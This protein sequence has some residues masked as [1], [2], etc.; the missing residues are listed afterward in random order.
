LEKFVNVIKKNGSLLQNLFRQYS[1][2]MNNTRKRTFHSAFMLLNTDHRVQ[3]NTGIAIAA[4]GQKSEIGPP[5]NGHPMGRES[6][7][8]HGCVTGRVDELAVTSGS[9]IDRC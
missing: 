6:A 1:A 8:W 7:S 5:Q 3:Y 4:S 2:T 9:R